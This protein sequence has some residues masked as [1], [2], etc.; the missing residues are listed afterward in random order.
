MRMNLKLLYFTVFSS[1]LTALAL[2]LS[3]SRLLGNVFGTSNLVWAAII[4]LILVYLAAGYLLGGR[5]ADRSPR[6]ETLFTILAWA[7]LTSGLVPF[8][9]RPVLALAANAFDALQLGVLFGAFSAVLVL[10]AAPVIL[11]G[12]VSPFA[13][14]LALQGLDSSGRVSGNLYA[15]STLGSFI[16]TFLPPLVM[17]PLLGTT[18]TFLCFSLYLLLVA[19]AGLGWSGARR[20]LLTLLWML[21]V[22]VALFIFSIG[23]T[24]KNTTGQIYEAESAYNYIQVLEVDGYHWLRLNEGQGIH[25]VYHPSDLDYAGPWEQ[26]LVAPF[27]NRAPYPPT[28]VKRIAIIGLAGGTLARQATAVLGAVAI[29]GFEIDPQIIQVGREYFGMD[30]PNLNAIAADGRW[31]L[32]HSN[33]VYQ[34][35]AIDA[36]RPPY[37]PWHLTT[38]EFFEEVRQH[39]SAD[40]VLAMN[41]GSDPNDQRLIE[42]LVGTLKTVYASVYMMEVPG[43]F[44]YM[45]YATVQPTQ[46]ED[47]Y[48]NFVELS[49][50]EA[51][52]LLI[53][54]LRRFIENQRLAPVTRV[55]SNG[56][57]A[58]LPVFT[59][60]RAPVEWITNSMVL[61]V[62]FFE[63]SELIR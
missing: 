10:F 37:I 17:I 50:Q 25:S 22:I 45:L 13:V 30:L 29:D 12:M 48:L 24:I 28:R 38:R 58:P 27:F 39:L 15:I 2:E 62:V 18:L 61:Q 34:V 3:A 49:A 21:P 41:V 1:G 43:T 32:A 53:T 4:G 14:R 60:D 55:L 57:T 20:R 8:V 47:L 42:G 16:G 9:A 56:D 51:H 36:Y 26:F 33:Q 63:D 23:R 5:W 11:L 35:V 7:A 31:G 46:A 54:A 59:D 52:P 40:G 44:N 19:L 6:P